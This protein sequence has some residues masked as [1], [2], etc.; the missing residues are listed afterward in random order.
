METMTVH[1]Q[2]CQQ[3]LSWC[4]FNSDILNDSRLTLYLGQPMHRFKIDIS[5][6]YVIW[7]GIRDR[8]ILRV[9]SGKII[10]RF[11][12]HLND[13]DVLQYYSHGLYATWATIP[14]SYK[15]SNPFP[16][17]PFKDRMRGVER[18]LSIVLAPVLLG[19]RFPANVEMVAVNPPE[20]YEPVNPFGQFRKKQANPFLS[21]ESD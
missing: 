16:T 13:P 8:K 17:T 6:V 14:L 2:K 15:S 5:G 3:I 12:K 21:K 10:Q 19:E 9:G 7:A 1:W 11:R 4:R 20:W 18:Y